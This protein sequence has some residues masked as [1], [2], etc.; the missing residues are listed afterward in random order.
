MVLWFLYKLI[1]TSHLSIDGEIFAA[2]GKLKR[3]KG[4]QATLGRVAAELDQ[5]QGSMMIDIYQW[6]ISFTIL[7]D[8]NI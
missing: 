8:M 1:V 2:N 5:L 3:K 7:R 6:H 4:G